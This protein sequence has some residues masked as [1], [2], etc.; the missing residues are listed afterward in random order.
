MPAIVEPARPFSPEPYTARHRAE[1]TG[2]A[3]TSHK[4][5]AARRELFCSIPPRWCGTSPAPRRNNASPCPPG[6]RRREVPLAATGPPRQALRSLPRRHRQW[7]DGGQVRTSGPLEPEQHSEDAAR[8]I[9][10]KPTDRQSPLSPSARM[11]ATS[12]PPPVAT[13]SCGIIAGKKKKYALPARRARDDVTT[14]RFTPQGTLVTTSR[15]K[16]VR[17]YNLGTTGAV[18]WRTNLRQSLR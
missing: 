16:A 6:R 4:S 13:S 14:V 3:V 18:P 11:A 7:S 17:I 8:G 12:P 10:R 1:V 9:T 15:D 2:V 5:R